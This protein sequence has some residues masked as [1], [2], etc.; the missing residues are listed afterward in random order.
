MSQWPVP[1]F[2]PSAAT[3][4]Y[5]PCVGVPAASIQTSMGYTYIYI[6]MNIS[7]YNIL[8]NICV[9]LYVYDYIYIRSYCTSYFKLSRCIH[10]VIYINTD[11]HLHI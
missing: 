6:Y 10:I 5:D 3:C 4:C 1:S 2:E 8:Y 7:E 9:L 11:I